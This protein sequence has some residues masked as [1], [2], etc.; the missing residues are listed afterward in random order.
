VQVQKKNFNSFF[1]TETM[2]PTVKAL[3]T[4]EH[5]AHNSAK[6]ENCN[7]GGLSLEL[8]KCSAVVTWSI[9]L[10][11]SLLIVICQFGVFSPMPVYS[12]FI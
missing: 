10:W 4:K 6:R 9:V 1:L 12:R 3:S 8:K 7:Y 11:L 2:S 5:I